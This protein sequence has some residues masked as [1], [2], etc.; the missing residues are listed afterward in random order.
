VKSLGPA[1]VISNSVAEFGIEV[2]LTSI[3]VEVVVKDSCLK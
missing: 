2:S 1:I 3:C